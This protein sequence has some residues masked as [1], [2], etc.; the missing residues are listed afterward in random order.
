MKSFL[1]LLVAFALA[2][3]L[4]PDWPASAAVVKSGSAGE[5]SS[6]TSWMLGLVCGVVLT[7]AARVRWCDLP[8]RLGQW[9]REQSVRAGWAALGLCYTWVLLFY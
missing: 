2:M 5:A 7:I 1:R 8:Q 6:Q 4:L 3:I 9:L